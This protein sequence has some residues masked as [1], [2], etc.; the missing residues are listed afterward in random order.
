MPHLPLPSTSFV[1][2]RAPRPPQ[3]W[4]DAAVDDNERFAWGCDLFDAGYFF[5]AHELWEACWRRAG[6]VG[7]VDD[8]DTRFVHG[9]IRLAAAGVKLLDDKPVSR[10]AHVDGA[11]CYFAG[12]DTPQRGIVPTTWR[13]AIEALRAGQR[14]RLS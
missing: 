11:V 12:I 7:G 4:A 1:K 13:T 3:G 2:G 9:L 10:L 14:P 8:P 5:E 6:D